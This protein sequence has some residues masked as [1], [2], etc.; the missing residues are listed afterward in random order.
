MARTPVVCSE[1]SSDR[2]AGLF[3]GGAIGQLLVERLRS[4]GLV[5]G[6]GEH[7]AQS[8]RRLERKGH[9]HVEQRGKREGVRLEPCER[10]E[11]RDRRSDDR[12]P[13]DEVQ[14]GRAG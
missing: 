4:P 11:E 8:R 12:N 6:R 2:D 1:S 10:H 9:G 14:V 7:D 13:P 3:R 5:A